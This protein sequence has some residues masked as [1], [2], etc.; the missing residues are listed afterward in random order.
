VDSPAKELPGFRHLGD[1]LIHQGSVVGFY[2]GTFESP[3]GEVFQRDIV[4]HPGA[5]SVVPVD[6]DDVILV[7][8]YRAP[9]DQLLLEIPAGKRDVE[10]EDTAVTASRELAEEIGMAAGSL[11]P[12][13]SMHHS[14]GF[15]DELQHIYLATDL[16]EV[17]QELDG[18]EEQHLTIERV[19]FET[20]I[21]WCY[22]GTITDAK[23]IVGILAAARRLGR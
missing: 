18:I 21:S 5:V 12:L 9:I 17:A 15:C 10:G 22:D 3:D 1:R 19:P 2:Q 20:A 14:P 11:E 13:V 4:R 23:S 6:G 7:R 16:H 8:Q